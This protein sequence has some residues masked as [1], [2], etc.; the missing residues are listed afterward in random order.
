MAG[1]GGKNWAFEEEV[2]SSDVN[3]YL[4]DQVV[5]RFADTATRTA[6]FGGAGEPTLA[7]GM[8]SYL[9]DQNKMYVY[10]GSSWKELA[11]PVNVGLR[12]VI[13]SSVSV[14]GAGSSASV[15]TD[16]MVTFNS[17]A[18]FSI[19]GCFSSAFRNYQIIIDYTSTTNANN[20]LRMR[21]G[22]VDNSTASSYVSQR[23]T[24]LN[25]TIGSLRQTLDSLQV[26]SSDTNGT[27]CTEITMFRPFLAERTAFL[28]RG[29]DGYLTSQAY[30]YNSQHNQAVSYDGFSFLPN[31][32]SV[33]GT[34]TVYGYFG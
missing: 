25:T 15:G 21:V 30:Y 22:G 18:S 3:G 4:A 16:G 28:V 23:I 34:C 13:P 12:N 11:Y 32:G 26:G 14:T 24:A 7:E 20:G 1:L 27:Q 19:N 33:S 10:D 9:D 31:G 6:G 29:Y 2:T 8:V 5:M 17:A